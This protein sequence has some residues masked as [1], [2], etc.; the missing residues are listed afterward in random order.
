MSADECPLPQARPTLSFRSCFDSLVRIIV[1]NLFATHQHAKITKSL[2]HHQPKVTYTR[3]TPRPSHHNGNHPKDRHS[4][5]RPPPHPLSRARPTRTGQR[6]NHHSSSRLLP[7]SHLDLRRPHHYHHHHTSHHHNT[8]PNTS[9][10]FRLSACHLRSPNGQPV[11]RLDRTKAKEELR[12]L[13]DCC[14]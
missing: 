12:I 2:Y 8:R 11:P 1:S 5:P 9:R 13:E 6:Y 3:P 4:P 14:A 10:H 7:Q